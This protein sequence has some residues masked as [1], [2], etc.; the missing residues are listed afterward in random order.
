MLPALLLLGCGDCASST[1]SQATERSAQAERNQ[2]AYVPLHILLEEQVGAASQPLNTRLFQTAG[3][4]DF[5]NRY[6]STV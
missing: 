4:V 2:P 5:K 3:T 6:S 1:S